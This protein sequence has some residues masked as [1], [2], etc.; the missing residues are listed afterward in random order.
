[1]VQP[2]GGH[3]T[4]LKKVTL[5]IITHICRKIQLSHQRLY[6]IELNAKQFLTELSSIFPADHKDKLIFKCCL[7]KTNNVFGYSTQDGTLT[8]KKLTNSFHYLN[9]VTESLQNISF[10]LNIFMELKKNVCSSFVILKKKKMR[11]TLLFPHCL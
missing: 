7:K 1:M 4:F 11:Y 6:F 2:M 10:K 5:F 3:R 8:C 9:I